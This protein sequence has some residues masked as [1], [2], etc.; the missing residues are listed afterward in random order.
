[1]YERLHLPPDYKPLQDQTPLIF[2]AGPIQGS[3]NWQRPTAESLLY[4]LPEAAVASP[5]RQADSAA[6][7]DYDE[8]VTWEINHLQRSR[9]LGVSAFW[10]AAQDPTL[11]YEPGRSYAQTTRVEIGRALGWNDQ[12]PFPFVVGFDPEY[13]KNGGGNERYIRAMCRLAGVSVYND[14]EDVIDQ[15]ILQLPEPT[16]ARVSIFQSM[17]RGLGLRRSE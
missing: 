14:L 8:Q 11:K 17:Q 13:T 7:F 5:R 16:K 3:P 12:K 4:H 15:T 6:E 10:F 1:M 2:L 9:L